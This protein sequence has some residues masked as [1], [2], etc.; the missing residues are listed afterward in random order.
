VK[1]MLAVRVRMLLVAGEGVVLVAEVQQSVHG[2]VQKQGGLLQNILSRVWVCEIERTRGGQL[3]KES[4]LVE[5]I[6][7][8]G[9]QGYV[10]QERRRVGQVIERWLCRCLVVAVSPPLPDIGIL[11]KHGQFTAHFGELREGS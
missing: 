11:D 7:V 3:V 5:Y 2:R 6:P 8:I 10:V 1:V 4:V 9:R